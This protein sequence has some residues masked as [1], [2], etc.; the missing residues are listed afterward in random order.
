MARA[1]VPLP[2]QKR[3]NGAEV[4]FHHSVGAGKFLGCEGFFPNF[5]KLAPK[6]FCATFAY[7]FSPTKVVKAS[8]WCNH[9][10]KVFMCF[11]VSLG[12]HF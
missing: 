9:Q 3:E 10:K 2:F 6:V 12:R 4:P 11:N 1:I 5:H 7:K 8:F